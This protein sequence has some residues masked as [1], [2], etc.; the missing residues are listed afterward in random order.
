MAEGPDTDS[1]EA[2]DA[3]RRTRLATER[4]VSFK[5]GVGAK[6][7]LGITQT[8]RAPRVPPGTSRPPT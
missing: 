8:S 7:N 2:V 1:A 5:A 3:T 4:Y 6:G